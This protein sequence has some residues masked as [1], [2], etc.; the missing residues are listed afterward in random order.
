M[1][2]FM[3]AKPPIPEPIIVAVRSRAAS[4]AGA[5]PDCAMASSAA[6]SA[7]WMKRSI[8]L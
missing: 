6:P 4:E 7:N 3:V 5:Q 2:C 8:R 1:A